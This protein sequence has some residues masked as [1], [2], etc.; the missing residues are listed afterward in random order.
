MV[1]HTCNTSYLGGRGL[2]IVSTW[3]AEAV[4]AAS[5]G[6]DQTVKALLGKGAQVNAVNQNGFTTLHSAASKNRHEIAVTLLERGANPDGK[7]HYEATAM[8]QAPAKGNLKMIHIFLYYKASISIQD[9]EATWEAEAGESLAPGRHMMQRA[10]IA[11]L[12]SS[13]DNDS[14]TLSQKKSKQW[15]FRIKLVQLGAGPIKKGP[16]GQAEWLTPVIPALWEAKAMDHLWYR[17]NSHFVAQAG[18]QRHGSLQL[19]PPSDSPASA[20]QVAGTTAV[21]HHTKII[22]VLL[23]EMG[24]HHVGQ[25]GLKLLSCPP[26]PPKESAGITG[27]IRTKIKEVNFN[28]QQLLMGSHYVAQ[29]GLELL[30]SS[31]PPASASQSFVITGVQDTGTRII[32]DGNWVCGDGQH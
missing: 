18:V 29:A 16:E 11:Q 24:F 30:A 19:P 7:D 1:V 13:L 32:R 31:D 4:I 23:V 2:R 21:H 8:Y 15:L 25:A 28:I 17:R 3:E 26:W 22:F 20:S 10:E 5:A 14:K 6:Q 27:T 9:T 12:H